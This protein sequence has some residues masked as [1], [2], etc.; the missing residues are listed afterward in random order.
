[1]KLSTSNF[2]KHTKQ[3][4]KDRYGN[5]RPIN[6]SNIHSEDLDTWK[7]ATDDVVEFGRRVFRWGECK[8]VSKQSNSYRRNPK[9]T[10]RTLT[11]KYRKETDKIFEDTELS[12]KSKV[13]KLREMHSTI[14]PE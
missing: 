3:D 10:L 4:L 7:T 13:L 12:D 2:S 9:E 1:M 8:L 5:K 14:A 11:A 6:Y